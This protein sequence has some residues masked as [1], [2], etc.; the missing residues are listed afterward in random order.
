[1][2][3]DRD[4]RDLQPDGGL[5]EIAHSN[6]RPQFKILQAI[7]RELLPGIQR[8]RSAS[9]RVQHRRAVSVLSRG[10]PIICNLVDEGEHATYDV[11]KLAAHVTSL[12]SARSTRTAQGLNG[13]GR[14][15]RKGNSWVGSRSKML[16]GNQAKYLGIILGIT[17]ASRLIAQQASIFCGL[18]LQTTGQ[19][20]DIQG[21]D[22]WVMDPNV[23]FSDD[24]KPLSD[25]DLYRV[26][27]VPGVAWAVQFYKGLTRSRL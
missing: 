5:A 1:M 17:F 25:S 14:A 7:L 20:R 13:R 21:A 18:M 23:Q 15:A 8:R 26:R 24:V 16:T 12:R 19:I 9:H 27:G 22:I 2:H 3:E 10:N 11:E 4:A 6:I